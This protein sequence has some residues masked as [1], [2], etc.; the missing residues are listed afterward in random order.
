MAEKEKKGQKARTP[1]SRYFRETTWRTAQG[2][3][4]HLAG[5]AAA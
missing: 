5:G 3:L 1:S 4:A 2:H